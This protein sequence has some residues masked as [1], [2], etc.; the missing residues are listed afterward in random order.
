MDEQVPNSVELIDNHL[1]QF[2]DESDN[3][4]V[5]DEIESRVIHSDV[6]IIPAN[7]ERSFNILLSCGM[8]A[9]PMQ[10]PEEIDAP[11]YAEVM[12]LLPR[13]WSLDYDSFAD[14]RNYW[15]IRIL[16][17]LSMLPHPDKTWLGYGHTYETE[18]ADG[19]DFN[20]IILLNSNQLSDDFI[21]FESEEGPVEIFSVIPLYPEELEFKK[22]HGREALL[23]KFDEY[24]ID[25][26]VD[27][28]RAN[29][30]LS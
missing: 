11:A 12:I 1:D 20:S 27:V 10:I 15:P 19:V 21:F 9:L 29:T 24:D 16:K 14:E 30:C 25:E 13:D 22:T 3:I 8:S 7:E 6:Y 28:N 4:M 5:L 2:F 26:V 18:F 23:E 17:E